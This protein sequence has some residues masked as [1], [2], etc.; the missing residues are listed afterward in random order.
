LDRNPLDGTKLRVIR[1]MLGANKGLRTLNMNQC[2][3]G[4]D[5][6]LFLALGFI[7]NGALRNLAI[8]DNN[9]GDVGVDHLSQQM[10]ASGVNF[11]LEILDLSSNYITDI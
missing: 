8:A 2:S 10:I 5:G 11:R 4:Q 3:L 9:F 6:C 1:E 7:K